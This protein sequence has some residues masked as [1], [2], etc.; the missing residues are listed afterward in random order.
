MHV[1]SL[2]QT[3]PRAYANSI[4]HVCHSDHKAELAVSGFLSNFRRGDV[5]VPYLGKLLR[6]NV[7]AAAAAAAAEKRETVWLPLPFHPLLMQPLQ[8]AVRELNG[9]ALVNTVYQN[10][11]NGKRCKPL[12]RIAWG[13]RLPAQ[14]KRV[15]ASNAKVLKS[16]LARKA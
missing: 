7:E 12:V 4:R 16:Y 11:Y 2:H 9:D 6:S 5:Q 10:A 14:W 15:R 1:P 3:W 8:A 13:N